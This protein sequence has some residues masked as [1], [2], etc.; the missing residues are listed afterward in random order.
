L[1]GIAG[2]LYFDGR[3]AH[4]R[5]LEKM[6]ASLAHRS[7][8]GGEIWCQGPVGLANCRFATTLEA[9]SSSQP[10]VEDD[11]RLVITADA[12]IDNRQDLAP[13]LGLL[14]DEAKRPDEYFILK[15]YEKWGPDCASKLLGDFAFVIWDRNRHQF[16]CARDP[17]GVKPFY[18]CHSSSGF[19]FASEIKAILAL[20]EIP[21]KLNESCLLD[22]LID[23]RQDKQ[24]TMFEG[25][26]RLPPAHYLTVEHG[27]H[28]IESYWSLDPQKE[29]RFRTDQDYAER[30]L[31]LFTQAVGARL[32]SSVPVA[33]ALSGGLD[34][35]AVA[36]V[37]RSLLPQSGA[38]PLNTFSAVFSGLPGPERS[39]L[40]EREYID[41]VLSTGGFQPNFVDMGPIGPMTA[42]EE[43]LR[44]LDEPISAPTVPMFRALY[45]AASAQGIGVY[46]E[47]IDG[48]LVV[49][50]GF[51]RFLDLIHNFELATWKKEVHD[52]SSR[53]GWSQIDIIKRFTLRSLIPPSIYQKMRRIRRRK[54]TSGN[55]MDYFSRDFVQQES[56]KNRIDQYGRRK[57]SLPPSA[58]QAHYQK[59]TSG[60]M[61]L[62][63]ELLDKI[64][65]N[66]NIEVR[67]PFYDH[68]LIE[69]CLAIPANQKLSHGWS[70]YILR[71]SLNGI[72]PEEVRWRYSKADFWP[73]FKSGLLRSSESL[74]GGAK[75]SKGSYLAPYLDVDRLRA[76]F[77][78]FTSGQVC[79]TGD[80]EIL[81]RSTLLSN[82]IKLNQP[83]VS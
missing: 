75:S 82:W 18:F 49:S 73:Y 6:T 69:Y 60:T 62:S 46:L 2:V 48:D 45:Q 83:S 52:V 72:V 63:L 20:G 64:A 33:S 26:A 74:L 4:P 11:G 39:L 61:P 28:R 68:R 10:L 70:R 12:R 50:H 17:V 29:I 15:T 32:R 80:I 56:I 59:L 77:Q 54:K 8:D 76:L 78:R 22:F 24:I 13:L 65:S 53:S 79:P 66:C 43:L 30:F 57:N 21:V 1:S 35:S 41:K 7:V 44:M 16:F 47:G 9:K 37:A 42:T 36:C 51:E 3:E 71:N 5:L 81:Y 34:S 25:I 23:D 19:F 40:D 55:V 38:R 67:Y 27:V 58:K 31:E 14:R